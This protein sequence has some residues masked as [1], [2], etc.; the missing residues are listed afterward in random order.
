MIHPSFSELFIENEYGIGYLDY[1][2]APDPAMVK[3]AKE[4]F[5]ICTD[6]SNACINC[7]L[8]QVDKYQNSD[9]WCIRVKQAHVYKEKN[10]KESAGFLRKYQR[11]KLLKREGELD[12]ST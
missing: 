2:K 11:V 7:Q 10:L 4:N 1:W 5:N 6:C 8:Q 9:N 3:E 12:T